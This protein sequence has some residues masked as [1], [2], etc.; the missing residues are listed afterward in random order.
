VIK[1]KDSEQVHNFEVL[2]GENYGILSTSH[3]KTRDLIFHENDQVEFEI[4]S[5]KKI[6][7]NLTCHNGVKRLLLINLSY[8][9]PVNINGENMTYELS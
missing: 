3:G 9:V 5:S 2:Q 7:K 4:G 6:K 1:E 8:D